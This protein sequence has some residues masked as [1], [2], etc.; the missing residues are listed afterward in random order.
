VFHRS[1]FLELLQ[2]DQVSQKENIWRYLKQVFT[3]QILNQQSHRTQWKSEQQPQ[4]HYYLLASSSLFS[5]AR[6]HQT[7]VNC[8]C[9]SQGSAATQGNIKLQLLVC[10]KFS[11]KLQ[12]E[13]R[14]EFNQHLMFSLT[15]PHTPQ[16]F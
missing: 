6:M 1:S 3:G 10:V 14:F 16:P 11:A 13:T 5:A 7:P 12:T 9:F 2:V 15:T 8:N 4:N